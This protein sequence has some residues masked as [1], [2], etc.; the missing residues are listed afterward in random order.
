M[1]AILAFVLAC[2][3]ALTDVQDLGLGESKN[4]DSD[5]APV[6]TG[7]CAQA[8]TAEACSSAKSSCQWANNACGDSE[9]LGAAL[10]SAVPAFSTP[11]PV[12]REL[13]EGLENFVAFSKPK[14]VEVTIDQ[15]TA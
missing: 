4:D 3:M 5:T 10:P 14:P 13:G 11:K 8:T 6:A 9:E 12:E 2:S 15:I 7:A 1:F